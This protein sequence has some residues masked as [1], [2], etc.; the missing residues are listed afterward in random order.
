[1]EIIPTKK[2]INRDGIKA[3]K[4]GQKSNPFSH[5][6]NPKKPSWLRIKAD[7]NPNF[8]KVK[9]QVSEKNFIPFV[10]KLIVQTSMNAGLL[11]QQPSC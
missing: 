1:M 3:L 10:R 11:E 8:H 9:E 5:I 6:P 2:V 4:N 7:S